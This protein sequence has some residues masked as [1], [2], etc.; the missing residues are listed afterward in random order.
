MEASN[1]GA[2]EGGSVHRARHRAALRNRTRACRTRRELPLLLRPQDR[3]SNTRADSSSCPAAWAHLDELFE[4]FTMVQTGKITS[5]PIVLF[6]TDYWGGLVDWMR[7]TL[8][9]AGTISEADMN[10]FTLTDD[11]DEVVAAIGP[12]TNPNSA[13]SAGSNPVDGRSRGGDAPR[14]GANDS[15]WPRRGNPAIMAFN[16]HRF[17]LRIR[18][19]TDD[20]R[21]GQPPVPI[22]STSGARRPRSNLRER[23]DRPRVPDHQPSA[24]TSCSSASTPGAMRL[25]PRA[26]PVRAAQRPGPGST[27]N[28]RVAA[29]RDVV[30]SAPPGTGS[31]HRSTPAAMVCRPVRRRAPHVRRHRPG[32]TA[33]ATM[34]TRTDHHRPTPDREEHLSLAASAG[35]GRFT[36]PAIRCCWRSRKDFVSEAIGTW[37]RRPSVRYDRCAALAIEG[38]GGDPH[39]VCGTTAPSM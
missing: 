19:H 8:L 23:G 30:S 14:A 33:R 31:A 17:L 25:G 15:I 38:C 26:G 21:R 12:G 10:M 2:C 37:P 9:A 27:P 18:S 13:N 28:S 11:I 29:R 3:S 1:L 5:F 39:H 34:C 22:S 32:Q 20:R 36:A 24:V 35:L 4:A 16:R 6:G 7:D